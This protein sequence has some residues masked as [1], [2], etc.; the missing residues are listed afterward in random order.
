MRPFFSNRPQT[1]TFI[2]SL[3]FCALFL[4]PSLSQAQKRLRLVVYEVGVTGCSGC[5]GG[6]FS[7]PND[8]YWSWEGGNIS[9]NCF[10]RNNVNPA[11]TVNPGNRVLFDETYDCPTDWP[12]GNLGYTWY[13]DETDGACGCLVGALTCS[14]NQTGQS[15]AYPGTGNGNFNLPQQTLSGAG[16]CGC[17]TYT[18]RARWEVSGNFIP[19]DYNNDMCNAGNLGTFAFNS[20]ASLA[21]QGNTSACD[22]CQPGEPNC[23]NDPSVWYRMT[24]GATVATNLDIEVDVTGGGMDAYV[25]VYTDP[26]NCNTLNDLVLIEDA[27]AIPNPFGNSD[28]TVTLECPQPNTTY[29]IQVDGLDVTGG[30][31]NFTVNVSDNGQARASNDLICNAITLTPYTLGGTINSTNHNN[32]CT[33]VS[34]GEPV[35][36]AFGLDQTVWFTFTTPA[37]VGANTVIEAINSGSDNIDLQ[38]ALYTSSNGTCTGTLTEVESDYDP[39]IF[40]EEMDLDC[41]PPNTTFFLQVDGSAIILTDL[42]QGTFDIRITDDGNAQ[43]TNDSICNAT[44]M[45]RIPDLGL[46]SLPNENN[47]CSGVQAGEPDPLSHGLD[48]T[49][50]YSFQPPSSGSVEIELLSNPADNIDLQVSVWESSNDSCDGFFGEIESFDATLANSITGGEKLRLK[51]LDT[52]RTYFIQVDGASFPLPPLDALV[53]G[54]FTLNVND[55]NVTAAPNDSICN[56]IPMG[57]P[58]G[59]PVTLTNQNNFCANNILDPFPSEFGTNTTVWYSFIAPASGRVEIEATSD[60]NNTGDYIDLQL[61]VFAADGDSC[62]GILTE[63]KSEHNDLLEFPPFSRSET[64]EVECL[65]P[66][67]IYW[68]MIDG[69][70]DPDDLDGFFDLTI[71]EQ[72]GPPPITNDDICG[73]TS[74]GQVPTG[75]NVGSNNEHNFCATTEVGEPVPS[76]FGI[77]A[78]VWYTF[79]APA[80]GNVTIDLVSDPQNFGDNVELQIAVYA[81]DNNTCTGNL[82]EVD[83]D[84]DPLA[85]VNFDETL[86]VTCLDSGRIYWIQVDGVDFPIPPLDPAWL[87][88]YFGITI[89]DDPPLSPLP[90]N[91]SICSSFDMGTIPSGGSSPVY[92][93]SNF[94]A[95]TETGEPN[96]T[97]CNNFFDFLC[98]ETVWFH[99]TTSN[100]PGTI[101]INVFNTNGID[102]A[103]TVYEA[104]NWPSCSFNDLTE[105]ASADNLLSFNVNQD[106]ECLKPNATYYIQID[107]LDIIGDYGTFDL[108]VTDDGTPV[109]TPPNDDICNASPLGVIP[110]GGASALTPGNNFCATTEPGEPNVDP[111]VIITNLTCDE[112][113]WYSF[114]TSANP[115][116]ITVTVNNTNGIVP[117]VQIYQVNNAPSCNFNDLVEVDNFVGLI[118]G[119]SV[120]IPCLLPNSIYYVQIDGNDLLGNNGTFDIQVSDNGTPNQFAPFDNICSAGNLGTVP[121]GGSTATLSTHNFCATT[122]PGEPGVSGCNPLTDP[123]CDETVWLYFTTPATPGLTTVTVNNTNGIDAE[124]TIYEVSQWPAC[125]WIFL[126]EIANQDDAF[127]TNASVDLPCLPPNRSYYVQVDGVD[128]LG[129]EGT[130]D[131]TVSDDGSM[132]SYPVNDSVCNATPLGIVP[133]GGATT[134][135][136]GSNFCAGEEPGEPNVSGLTTVTASAYDESVWYS[137][138]TSGTPG[139][140]TIDI[141]NTSG[142]YGV[143][144]VYAVSPQGSCSFPN[145]QFLRGATTTSFGP[146]S[147]DVVCLDPNS[148]YLIQVDGLDLLGDEGTFDIRVTDDG[149]PVAAPTYDQICNASP[150]G[151]PSGGSVGPFIFNNNCADEEFQEP[152]V[153]GNDET[154][155]FTFIA[156]PSGDVNIDINSIQYIDVNF[157]VYHS[158]SGACDFDSLYQ[159]GNNHDNLISFDADTDETCLIPGATYYI[160]VDGNDILGDYGTFNITIT[161]NNASFTPPSNDDPCSSA[162]TVP[163]GTDPC[164]GS[165]AWNVY[166]YGNPTVSINDPYVQGCGDNCGDTW[167]T[168]T[169]PASGTVLL[170]GNDE[171]G[172]LGLNNSQMNVVAYQ[173]PC[174][175]LTP[176]G[177]CD[178]GGVFNDPQYYI[179][180]APGTQVYLQV[181]DDGGNDINEDFG[182]CLTDRCGSDSCPTAT[183][184]LPG[185]PYCFDT[186]GAGGETI[187]QDPGYDECGDGSDPG[188]SVYFSYVNNCESFTVRINANIGGTCILDEPTDGLSFALYQDSTPCDNMPQALL[189]C[190]QTDVCLGNTWVFVRTYTNVPIGTQHI[191]QLDGFDLTGNNNG[192]IQID[193]NCP[194]PIDF[195]AFNGYNDGPVNE[196]VWTTN[197]NSKEGYFQ[198][199]KSLDGDSFFP[200]GEVDGNEFIP[201]SGGSS[202][203]SGQGGSSSETLNYGFTDQGPAPGHNYYRLRYVSVNAEVEYSDIIDI[204][205][206]EEKLF[207]IVG[208]YPNPANQEINL[209]LFALQ[210]GKAS[211]KIADIYGKVVLTK[212]LSLI[213]GLNKH[214]LPLDQLSAGMY[215]I[216]IQG[217]QS[218]FSAVARFIKQ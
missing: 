24:T 203:S 153:S 64:M 184:M 151:N 164:Q 1:R 129:D 103:F 136:S 132:N 98:D 79:Q 172:F 150:L 200:L 89:N 206:D 93:G 41:L 211:L 196:L 87:E 158:S 59:S 207:Q 18:Y 21:G 12:G 208:L 131:I 135:I 70:D 154:V 50:W 112:T 182:L 86:S 36:N 43:P 160:Q 193:E 115:G 216:H 26:A 143:V 91:D 128:L 138:T 57:N 171:Y 75:G 110:S 4:W 191:I 183:P 72:P 125:N 10:G 178:N 177:L 122:E 45:G 175:N 66:G 202:G 47:F 22:D 106:V 205:F 120:T 157:N 63:I 97:N 214:K 39:L 88:G 176:M 187:P 48:Q 201:N 144:N 35:P 179:S 107:G 130:F 90:T 74:L 33:G 117:D 65:E 204:Y 94:C 61:A 17:V 14:D 195:L 155:W 210:E 170:E 81:S 58:T 152:N 174:N 92:S 180:A 102:V 2:L 197:E 168:F 163:V 100:T 162:I 118:G 20:T 186:D 6:L 149:V 159:V 5:D 3:F 11:Y 104:N 83:S 156:P 42:H 139:T 116:D 96:V 169:M 212:D 123:A 199:E 44:D 137:F 30:D 16:G 19:E 142:I 69:S 101:N 28:V 62:S 173:G 31:G 188:H 84:Y 46:V 167:Y 217:G 166:N 192:I 121:V 8:H 213:E 190:E 181:F 113:V 68:L 32:L 147:V 56:A 189:D 52:A 124:I 7:S 114:T 99:F 126:T 140:C 146:V 215:L 161:D 111:C 15:F 80:S 29:W 82:V 54:I 27:S 38:V 40:D 119:G 60:P 76:S 198:I 67:R 73:A 127:S 133:S 185:I 55:Y 13:V 141:L 209:D 49:V 53:E 145:L 77:D 108:Q 95:T 218:R 165:G 134:T 105:I 51:C 23:S 71:T 148:T 9:N 109:P 194:L 85:P 34:A 25:A 37:V 78:T